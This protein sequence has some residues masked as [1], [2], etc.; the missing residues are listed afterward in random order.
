MT[1]T[2]VVTCID[3][4]AEG[5]TTV[6]PTPYGGPRSPRCFTHKNGRKKAARKAAHGRYVER[7]YGITEEEYWA[8]YEAQGGRCYICRVATGKTKKLAVDHDHSCCPELPGCGKC[9]R[10]LGCGPCN[11]ML[12]LVRDDP[13]K[14]LRAIE[15]LVWP[16]AQRGAWYTRPESWDAI[17]DLYGVLVHD[18]D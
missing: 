5:V 13:T 2:K 15:V 7:T 8:L 16:P 12:A 4:L 9:V 14:L 18:R 6:R 17:S 11:S 10:F 3:C 1:E